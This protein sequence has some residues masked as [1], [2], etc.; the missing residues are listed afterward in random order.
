[1]PKFAKRIRRHKLHKLMKSSPIY[2][3]LQHYLIE[4][5]CIWL[6]LKLLTS[7]NPQW[8]ER[9]YFAAS[10]F[11]C[12]KSSAWKWTTIYTP[13]LFW[14]V[15]TDCVCVCVLFWFVATDCVCV[16]CFGLLQHIVCVCFVLVCCNRLCVCVLFW[17]KLVHYIYT[18]LSQNFIVTQAIIYIY[19]YMYMQNILIN[20]Y[21]VL[22]SCIQKI[23]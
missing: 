11:H 18:V 8:I 19:I 22:I 3:K 16:F 2:N 14:F 15:A 7:G 17:F 12:L 6:Y 13:P 20:S 9:N 21:N 1:L 23:M 5:A 4:H 10:C